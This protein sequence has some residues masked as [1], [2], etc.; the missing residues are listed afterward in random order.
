MFI[1]VKF[2]IF[3]KLYLIDICKKKRVNVGKNF[4]NF[5]NWFFGVLYFVIESEIVIFIF[6]YMK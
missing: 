3:W 6:V 2:F 5:F 1:F 4:G